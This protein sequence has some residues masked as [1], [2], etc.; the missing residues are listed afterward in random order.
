MDTLNQNEATPALD[1]TFARLAAEIEKATGS[2]D[3]KVYWTFEWS[4]DV[5]GP[6]KAYANIAYVNKTLRLYSSLPPSEITWDR[7][8]WATTKAADD[9]LIDPFADEVSTPLFPPNCLPAVLDKFCRDEAARKGVP[10]G[11]VAL[12]AIGTC[13]AALHTGIQIQLTNDTTFRQSAIL[14]VAVVGGPGT[15]KSP[16][17]SAVLEPLN[18]VEK[19]WR[20]EDKST[21]AAAKQAHDIWD[22]QRKK[23]IRMDKAAQDAALAAGAFG[24]EPSTSPFRRLVTNDA[25]VEALGKVLADNDDRGILLHSDELAGWI[26]SFDQYKT[27]GNDRQKFLTMWNGGS[28]TIDRASKEEPMYVEHAAVSIIGGIQPAKLTPIMVKQLSEDGLLQRFLV[29]D[30]GQRGPGEDRPPDE[31]ARLDYGHL[32]DRL[33]KYVPVHTDAPIRLSPEAR[34]VWLEVKNQIDAALI[35]NEGQAAYV[36]HL[37]KWEALFARIVLV[38]HAVEA[39]AGKSLPAEVTAETVRRAAHLAIKF[40]IPSSERFYG[41]TFG[42]SERQEDVQKI[43]SMILTHCAGWETIRPRDISEVHKEYRPGRNGHARLQSAMRTLEA[44][45]W[46]SALPTVSP[47]GGVAEWSLSPKVHANNLLRILMEKAR[48][49]TLRDLILEAGKVRVKELIQ[50]DEDFS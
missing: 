36:G 43:A 25:T 8:P 28:V 22:A 33:T 13:A 12:A 32:I 6:E 3:T 2:T 45:G 46:V 24:P 44:G 35:L 34:T 20:Q 5:D 30:M 10:V 37:L 4:D 21:I 27:G 31:K 15:A 19:R 16:M 50:P 1:E 48:K 18:T 11:A 14:W 41:D 7:N 9:D 42:K 26:G 47:L 49:K 17:L 38:L 40:L 39:P 23:Y 29:A